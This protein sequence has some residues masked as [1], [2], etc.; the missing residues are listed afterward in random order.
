MRRVGTGT[1]HP[2]DRWGE[3]RRRDVGTGG[4]PSGHRLGACH[5]HGHGP[6]LAGRRGRLRARRSSGE[7]GG[8]APTGHRDAG[9][10]PG[11][12]AAHGTGPRARHG[13]PA[14]PTAPGLDHAG[15]RIGRGGLGSSRIAPGGSHDH[16][17][18]GGGRCDRDDAGR[19]RPG[20]AGGRMMTRRAG[21][22]MGDRP[23]GRWARGR[24]ATVRGGRRGF[25]RVRGHGPRRRAGRP[26]RRLAGD[27]RP[28]RMPIG[29]RL[30]PLGR[31][32]R[33]GRHAP[34]QRGGRRV[35]GRPSRR[36][37]RNGRR[38]P[39]DRGPR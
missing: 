39:A 35:P 2:P 24:F 32:S 5:G 12:R 38:V 33:S 15:R 27:R 22:R 9:H 30:P 7:P 4:R 36:S 20:R 29:P 3:R 19:L 10:S 34:D 6:A 8:P 31:D 13:S 37:D 16:R 21:A 17:I 23:A 25:G 18:S 11:R 26:R 14:R 1:D 28:R